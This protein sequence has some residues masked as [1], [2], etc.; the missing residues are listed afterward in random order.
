MQDEF[1]DYHEARLLTDLR[2]FN[3]EL[4]DWLNWYNRER[5]FSAL[6]NRCS[7]AKPR[8]CFL[9][10]DC[11]VDIISVIFAGPIQSFD[12]K[13]AVVI[14]VVRR[15]KRPARMCYRMNVARNKIR[16][17]ISNTCDSFP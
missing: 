13:E 9:R 15:R 11:S 5:P 14:L 1:V 10:Y 6:P 3:F 7:G 17:V 8:F 2:V 16:S 12:P 4:L